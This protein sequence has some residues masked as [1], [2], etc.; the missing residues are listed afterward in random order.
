MIIFNAT[1][2]K[3]FKILYQ[4]WGFKNRELHSESKVIAQFLNLTFDGVFF[5]LIFDGGGCFC[6]PSFRS[7]KQ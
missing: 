6:P 4:Q 5:T 2:K 7:Q 3:Y 1:L